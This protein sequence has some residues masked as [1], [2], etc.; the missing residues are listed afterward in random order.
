[1]YKNTGYIYCTV[2]TRIYLRLFN[3]N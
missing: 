1:M 2:T 3:M